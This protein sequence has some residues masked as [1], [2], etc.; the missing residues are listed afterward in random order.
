[1]IHR[2]PHALKQSNIEKWTAR[3]KSMKPLSVARK[4]TV[5][6]TRNF[7]RGT[8]RSGKLLRWESCSGPKTKKC[9]G[10]TIVFTVTAIG[11]RRCAV[12]LTGSGLC[13]TRTRA[14]LRRIMPQSSSW[15]VGVGGSVRQTFLSKTAFK[16]LFRYRQS[17]GLS[18]SFR[19][20][21]NTNRR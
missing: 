13:A 8:A 16:T 21:G 1:M 11:S 5:T 4:R 9:S 18:S 6:K 12:P 7:V 15:A 19:L 3:Y 14:R 2:I 10:S 17:C 20:N